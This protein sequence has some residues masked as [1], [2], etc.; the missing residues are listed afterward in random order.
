[1]KNSLIVFLA[2]VAILLLSRSDAGKGPNVLQ[3]DVP[4]AFKVF[5]AFPYAVAISDADNDTIFECLTTMR[6]DFDPESKTVTYV[7]SISDGP[8]KRKHVS[9]HHTAGATPDATNF[10]VGKDSNEVE[11]AYVIW[12]DYKDCAI[13][14]V[15]HFADQCTL[16]VSKEV[17][18]LVPEYCLEQFHDACGVMVP[19]HDSDLCE[20]DQF[21]GEDDDE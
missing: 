9:L 18:D 6:K 13:T 16:W 21:D 8:G 12:S 17:E 2:A 10:T 5:A 7:W 15:P 19:L 20:D 14:E 4:D 3:R 1:M 11:V